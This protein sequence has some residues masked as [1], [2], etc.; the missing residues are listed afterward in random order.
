ML[1]GALLLRG[2]GRT[3]ARRSRIIDMAGSFTEGPSA[4]V[5]L[6]GMRMFLRLHPQS[7]RYRLIADGGV[8]YRTQTKQNEAKCSSGVRSAQSQTL[9]W[10]P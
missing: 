10:G 6:P 4:T 8:R 5:A 9:G 3:A 1:Y 2:D 7:G